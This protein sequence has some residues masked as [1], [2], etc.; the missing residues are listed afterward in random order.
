MIFCR[1]GRANFSPRESNLASSKCLYA[2]ASILRTSR[3]V[4]VS[5]KGQSSITTPISSRSSGSAVSGS[6]PRTL[7]S[8]P[9]RL[10][11]PSS[12]RIVVLLPAPFSPMSPMMQPVGRVKLTLSSAKAP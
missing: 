12:S 8:P 10:A 6:Q 4:M 5:G 3:S 2:A 1:S 11:R 9:E 7:T